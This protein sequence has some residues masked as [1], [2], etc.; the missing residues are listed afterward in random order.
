MKI[1][2]T[3][4]HVDQS[5]SLTAYAQEE[6]ERVGKHLLKDSRW[7][8][9]FSMGRY[10]YQVEV[11]VN[12]PWGHFKASSRADDFYEAVDLAAEKLERQ[13]QKKKEQ[14]QHH[15]KP[16][17]SKQGHLEHVNSQ[18]EYRVSADRKIA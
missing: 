6:F 5:P 15:K 4:R 17:L 9:F 3:Y 18:L 1:Q 10:D 7:Q 16:E 14:L 12:G 8:I 13:I 2:F 11:A